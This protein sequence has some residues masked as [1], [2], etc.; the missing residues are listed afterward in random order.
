MK[1]F[2][3][4]VPLYN[5]EKYIGE[6]IDSIINQDYDNWELIIVND[7]SKD[8]GRDIVLNY[9]NNDSRIKLIDQ[10]NSGVSVARNNGLKNAVGD[11]IIFL[12]SDDW[13]EPNSLSLISKYDS[14]FIILG[15][16]KCYV[17]RVDSIVDNN[18]EINNRSDVIDNIYLNEKIQGFLCT[19]VFKKS[20]INDHNMKFDEKIR[21]CEDL[22]FVDEYVKYCN[23]FNYIDVALYNYRMRKSSASFSAVK[24]KDTS[25]LDAYMYLIDKNK[26]DLNIINA[27]NYSFLCNYYKVKKYCTNEQKMFAKKICKNEKNIISNLSRGQKFRFYIVKYNYSLFLLLKKYK[28]KKL[29]LYD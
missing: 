9:S 5:T 15:F 18:V 11:F 29:N 12:D 13:L 4:I 8:N 27:L 26:D 10:S 14:D 16:N 6:C 3:I 19:K 7:G 25:S 28:D 2:S 21:I 22:I 17:D 1:K 20:I 24:N 23:S